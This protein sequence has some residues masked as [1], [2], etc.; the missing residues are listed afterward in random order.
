[1]DVFAQEPVIA[2]VFSNHVAA[3]IAVL[4]GLAIARFFD[5]TSVAL[6]RISY[7]VFRI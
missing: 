5:T 3:V 1:V 2:I 4:D 7:L 6:I